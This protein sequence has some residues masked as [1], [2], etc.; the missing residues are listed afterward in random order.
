MAINNSIC[1]YDHKPEVQIVSKKSEETQFQ[2][3]DIM[4]SDQLLNLLDIDFESK[5]DIVKNLKLGKMDISKL[6]EIPAG[7]HHIYQ[8][9][10]EDQNTRPFSIVIL[11]DESGSMNGSKINAQYAMVKTLYRTFS[12][13]LSQDK[14]FV[15]GHSGDSTPQ[16]FVYQ[17]PGRLDFMDTIDCMITDRMYKQNYDGPIVEAIHERVRKETSDR[18]IFLVLSD[19]HPSGHNYGS[20]KDFENYKQIL[21]KCKRDEFVVG[22]IL[23]QTDGCGIDL[24]NYTTK[25][26]HLTE[27][28][29]KVSNLVNHIVKTEFQ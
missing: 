7:N 12:M 20:Y 6:A 4:L 24:Y 10:I 15:Y 5:A 3:A 22:G 19:G 2:T 11:C 8:Q 14:I 27:F 29:K 16:L 21:E 1:T 25:I 28:P 13:I 26:N 23:I 18:I 9:M 17:E